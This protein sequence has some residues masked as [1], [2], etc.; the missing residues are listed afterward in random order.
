MKYRDAQILAQI[1]RLS[2]DGIAPS[3]SVHRSLHK[4]AV[5][6]F[7]NWER[8]CKE[9]EVRP[10]RR[11]WLCKTARRRDATAEIS[12]LAKALHVAQELGEINVSACM[13]YVRRG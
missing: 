9:A 4:T 12:E 1:R 2:T 5:N 8:A 6:R 7:G 3:T 11:S 13:D 10:R